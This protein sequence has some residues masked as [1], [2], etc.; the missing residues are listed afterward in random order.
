M[1]RAW[2]DGKRLGKYENGYDWLYHTARWKRRRLHQ[3]RKDPL[4]A[5][6]LADNIIKEARVAH[7]VIDH[8][9]DY[10]LFFSSPLQSLC[11][12][13][14]D[15]IREG[16]QVLSY[17][18]GCDVNGKPYRTHPIFIDH[19]KAK[20]GGIKRLDINAIKQRR[21]LFARISC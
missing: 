7:H 1:R 3:L 15:N 19:N 9:G 8:H 21:C 11:K 13:C 4:C 16:S 14:H 20:T 12:K 10:Q 6:C 5:A 2:A 18:R 17:Q